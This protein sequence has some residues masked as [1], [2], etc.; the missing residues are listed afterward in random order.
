M[1]ETAIHNDALYLY[2]SYKTRYACTLGGLSR[3]HYSYKPYV[4]IIPH[5]E[6]IDGNNRDSQGFKQ[7]GSQGNSHI[8]H[9]R[10]S[11]F[12]NQGCDLYVAQI[13]NGLICEV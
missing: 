6:L 4:T 11:E 8:C 2:D 5:V 12:R 9:G 7:S 1:G 3:R 10:S 13:H